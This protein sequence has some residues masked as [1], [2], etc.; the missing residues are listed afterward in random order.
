MRGE[1]AF[2]KRSSF[3]CIQLNARASALCNRLVS[4]VK[5]G[6]AKELSHEQGKSRK[7]RGRAAEHPERAK[8]GAVR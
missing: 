8:A 3:R 6:E 5:P 7:A 1:K 2:R 4:S